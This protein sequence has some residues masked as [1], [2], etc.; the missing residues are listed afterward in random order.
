MKIVCISDTHNRHW[1]LPALPEGDCIIHAGDMSTSG[2]QREISDFLAWFSETPYKYRILIAGNHDWLFERSPMSC[3][4]LVHG[5][6]GITYLED[7]GI[8]IEGIKFWGS[9]VQP[10]FHD[11]AFNRDTVGIQKHW[12]MIPDD[13]QV[14]IT[15]GPPYGYGD[16]L[17]HTQ[18]QHLGCPLLTE[19]IF[20]LPKLEL[21][22]SGHIHSGHGIITITGDHGNPA[23]LVNAAQ[24]NERYDIAYS[25]IEVEVN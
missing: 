4:E 1:D 5:Y 21:H 17:W 11:W 8:E 9:P 23:I 18:D 10:T 19:K 15:H 3:K 20:T 12:D 6:D 22:V 16:I 13:T 24:L 7:S 14:L 2:S 25:P